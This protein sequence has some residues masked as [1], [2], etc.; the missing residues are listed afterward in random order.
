MK[1]S[2]AICTRNRAQSLER[3]LQSL[4]R[5]HVPPETDWE[6]LIV[7]NGSTDG[8][9]ALIE[10]FADRL[11]VRRISEPKAG[12]SN[13]R[14]RAVDEA[15]GSYIIWT[16]DDVV[17]E[18]GWLAAYLGAF[19]AHPDAAVFGGK[20]L[21][22]LDPPTPRWFEEALPLL[23]YPLAHRDLGD[24]PLALSVPEDRIPYGANYA[25][26]MREQRRLRYDPD[27]GASPHHNRVGEEV[28][29]MTSILKSGGSGFWVPDAVAHH[30]IPTSRQ[31]ESY[32]FRYYEAQG[33][34][35][36]FVEGK[37][38]T[39]TW[40][41]VPR[42]LWLRL[43]KRLLRYQWERRTAPPRQWVKS[44]IEYAYDRGLFEH[45]RNAARSARR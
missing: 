17:L 7:D 21:P 43:P 12:L 5:L 35:A 15:Q 33:E 20:I 18:R 39:P 45:W 24:A 28:G 13:A 4:V 26:R 40:F 34:T 25:L 10:S 14:N 27:L 44:L 32:I 11:P 19:Q 38:A 8:T 30:C 23:G 16:D 3:A 31:S 29:V 36:A 41:S 42:W 6:L 1:I 22:V 9:A 2:V 37:Y